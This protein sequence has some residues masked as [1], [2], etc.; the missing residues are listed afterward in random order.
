MWMNEYEV[1]DA[2]RRFDDDDTPNLAR[3]ARILARLVAWTNRNSD[4]WPYWQKPHKAA[5]KL[6]DHLHE[7]TT[8]YYRGASI[9]D[10]SDTELNVA[11]RP[12]KA[13]LTRQGVDHDTILQEPP[14][15]PT[16]SSQDGPARGISEFRVHLGPDGSLSI[17]WQPPGEEARDAAILDRESTLSKMLT[18]ILI[19]VL[20]GHR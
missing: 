11:L 9:A 1:E 17:T 3:G 6:Q 20:A 19:D 10:L 15:P 5:S 2:T 14:P 7:A 13:F 12:V 4:G 16:L 8:A 18:A